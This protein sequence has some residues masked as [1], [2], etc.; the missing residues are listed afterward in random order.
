MTEKDKLIQR[1]W[2]LVDDYASTIDSLLSHMT[3]EQIKAFI[4]AW[5]GDEE[6]DQSGPPGEDND[7]EVGLDEDEDTSMINHYCC[8]N[9]DYEWADEWSCAADDDCVNCGTRHIT[10]YF[11]AEDE[12]DDNEE[13][14]RAVLA[15]LREDRVKGI[16]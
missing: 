1:A 11:S 13:G 3:E 4:T 7:P 15:Q 6:P 14:R 12:G 8:P 16:A 2:E 9:C 5:G 10:P